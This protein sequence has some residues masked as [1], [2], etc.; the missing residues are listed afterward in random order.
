MAEL[1]RQSLS[2]GQGY[3][4]VWSDNMYHFGQALMRTEGGHR[5]P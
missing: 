2:A 3:L 5:M 1:K 4:L